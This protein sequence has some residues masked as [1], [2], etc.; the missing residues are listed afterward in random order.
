MLEYE[1]FEWSLITNP[2]SAVQIS[3]SVSNMAGKNSNVM[4]LVKSF[5]PGVFWVP[6]Y[7]SLKCTKFKMTDL[8]QHTKIRTE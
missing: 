8:K 3:K 2:R 5:E 7:E 6:D 4:G 1:R